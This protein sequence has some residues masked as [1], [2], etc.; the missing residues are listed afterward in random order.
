M[1]R[2]RNHRC[3]STF[4]DRSKNN[5]GV[6]HSVKTCGNAANLRA[7]RARRRERDHPREPAM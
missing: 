1:K 7:S 6:W 3:A 4:Y 2:C 5:S